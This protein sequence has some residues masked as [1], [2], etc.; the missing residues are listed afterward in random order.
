MILKELL[1][2]SEG[3]SVEINVPFDADDLMQGIIG[4]AESMM[5]VLSDSILS[6]TVSDIDISDDRK[7][8]VWLER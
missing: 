3:V 8:V 2:V 7:L 4:D 5:T 1:E 6:R